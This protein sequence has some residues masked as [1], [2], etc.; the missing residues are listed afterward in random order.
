MKM[1]LT[2]RQSEIVNH[3][4][5]PILVNAGPGSGKTRILSERIINLV[6]K[7]NK[8]ILALTFNNKAAKEIK[9]R[10]EDRLGNDTDDKVYVG[11]IHSFCLDVISNKGNLIGLPTG[12]SIFESESDRLTI[13]KRAFNESSEI[14]HEISDI[15]TDANGLKNILQ[16]ISEYKKDFITPEMVMNTNDAK[17]MLLGK[18]YKSY[19]NM[20]L[21]QRAIDFDDI[22]FYSY[23]LFTNIP[24]I[25]QNYTRLYKYIF[26]DEAQDLNL[27]Q[28]KVLKSLCRNFNNLMFVGDP[29]QSIYGF[30]GSISEIMTKYFCDDFN[31]TVYDLYENFRSTKKIISAARKIHPDINSDSVYPLEGELEIYRFSNEQD[32]AKWINDK[33]EYMVNNGNE[34]VE[35]EIYYED[36]AVIARNRYVFNSLIELFEENDISFNYGSNSRVPESESNLMKVFEEG[37]KVITNPLDDV[38]YK[39]ILSLLKCK[40]IEEVEDNLENLLNLKFENSNDSNQNIYKII[41]EAWRILA[42]NEEDFRKSLEQI[43]IECKNSVFFEENELFLIE[44][45]ILMWKEHWKIYSSNTVKGQRSLSQFRNQVALGMT[46]SYNF[47]GI[48]LLTVHMSK[49]LGFDVVFIA[50]MNEGT[51]PDYRANNE[52][53]LREERNNMF[54]ALTRAKR[55]CYLTYPEVKKMPWGSY[56]NQVPSRFLADIVN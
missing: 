45:D 35:K 2:Q 13:L 3:I 32:E 26:V 30:N 33:I 34:W 6:N 10:V 27:T 20:M 44:N 9:S 12:L 36:I 11:T 31:P 16:R 21:S 29:A 50:G 1:N 23:E 5:G 38:H 28:Y 22:L 51:F 25:A 37:L 15:I 42:R 53:L 4:E 47:K 7:G 14:R 17:E 18:I 56:K 24:K 49:G 48:S 40:M 46:Q 41:S 39:Y 54:V 52:K 8:R 43:H 19:N 55:V